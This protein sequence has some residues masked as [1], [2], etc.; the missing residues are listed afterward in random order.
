[1]SAGTRFGILVY[2]EVEPIDVGATYGVLSMARRAFPQIEMFLVAERA[3]PV[4]LTNNLIVNAHHGYADCPPA[5]VIVVTGGGGWKQQVEN[6][7]TLSFLRGL[8]ASTLIASVCTGGMIVAAAGL[9]DG[10][11]ATTRRCGIPSEPTPLELMGKSN[12]KV[13]PV[14][15]LIVD[16]GR[17]ITG[18]GVSLSLDTMFYLLARILGPAAADEVARLTE[19]T[20]ARRANQTHLKSYIS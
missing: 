9:L 16:N 14:E 17:I 18:G 11:K 15:A 10:H 8:P 1:M 20:H 6:T 2:D 12:P 13:E 5:D 3:G 19:Y 7:A 4:R